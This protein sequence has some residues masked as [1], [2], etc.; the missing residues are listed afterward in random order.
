MIF[1]PDALFELVARQAVKLRVPVPVSAATMRA[2]VAEAERLATGRM[3]K[4]PAALSGRPRARS[5]GRR[6]RLSS[7]PMG[8]PPPSRRALRFAMILAA[9]VASVTSGAVIGCGPDMTEVWVCQNP[10]TGK[11][12]VTIYDANHYVNG[13]ADPCHCYDPCGPEKTCPIVVDAGAPSP[14][15]DTGDGGL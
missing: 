11:D 5:G 13:V 2:I 6:P 8:P 4:E 10:V 9:L 15:C 3:G 7:R 1:D 12:D 14:G